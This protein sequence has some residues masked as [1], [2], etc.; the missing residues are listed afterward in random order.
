MSDMD[1]HDG[2][3]NGNRSRFRPP[4]RVVTSLCLLI[5]L[6]GTACG[7]RASKNEGAAAKAPAPAEQPAAQP[8]SGEATTA[9]AATPAETPAATPAGS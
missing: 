6:V 3:V 8:P 5:A 7:G 2:S 4:A 1:L 9:P